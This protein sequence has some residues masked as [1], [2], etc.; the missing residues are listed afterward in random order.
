MRLLTHNMLVSNAAGVAEPLQDRVSAAPGGAKRSV[1]VM[2]CLIMA[3][4]K[5][6]TQAM[7]SPRRPRSQLCQ[8]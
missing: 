8:W 3:S 1:R 2:R 5:A 7:A 4:S 6:A